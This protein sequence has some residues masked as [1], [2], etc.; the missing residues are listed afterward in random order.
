MRKNESKVRLNK[1]EISVFV[2][3][4][5]NITYILYTIDGSFRLIYN[6]FSVSSKNTD[7]IN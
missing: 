1:Y 4:T 6:V 3:I 5:L 7:R 2:K